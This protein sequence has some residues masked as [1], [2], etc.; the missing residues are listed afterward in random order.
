MTD[1]EGAPTIRGIRRRVACLLLMGIVVPD[2]PS[3]LAQTPGAATTTL[4]T[5]EDLLFLRHMIVHHEQALDLTALVPSR[6]GRDELVRFA[7]QV[8]GAQRAEIDQMESLLTLAADRGM[9]VPHHDAHADQPMPGLLPKAQMDAM[10][11]AKGAA[12]ERLWLEGMIVHHE[13]ALTMGRAQQ[14][15]QSESGRQPYGIDVLVD[16][17]LVAQRA[18]IA[19]MKAWLTQWGLSSSG[20]RSDASSR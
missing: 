17:I 13:G 15:R 7:R 14:R 2:A 9:T 1:T 6:T 11:A 20:R 4:Y 18:E 5:Q 12:F 3:V 16:E 19:K 10:A 8:D